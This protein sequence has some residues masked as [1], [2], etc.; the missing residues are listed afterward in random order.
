MK[1]A[2]RPEPV[3][4][5]QI[6]D[7]SELD[8]LRASF[9]LC[10]PRVCPSASPKTR[11]DSLAQVARPAT[12]VPPAIPPPPEFSREALDSYLAAAEARQRTDAPEGEPEQVPA[13]VTVAQVAAAASASAAAPANERSYQVRF[14]G[15]ATRLS[16]EAIQ[17]LYAWIQ[18]FDDVP[19]RYALRITGP[20][21]RATADRRL[22]AVYQALRSYG[23][24]VFRLSS[25]FAP[26]AA[27][28]SEHDGK[29][30]TVTVTAFAGFV[31]ESEQPNPAAYGDRGTLA[32]ERAADLDTSTSPA[33]SL[34][35]STLN[36]E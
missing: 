14:T 28:D 13:I 16:P 12:S 29:T 4:V 25:S 30:V 8:G 15:T 5:V 23:V 19:I 34:Q 24:P 20:V 18:H 2:Y 22:G 27:P 6:T 26:T 1:A 7:W 3:R 9:V 17:D 11:I 33:R 31:S 32:D 10:G 35:P 36:Q 21:G